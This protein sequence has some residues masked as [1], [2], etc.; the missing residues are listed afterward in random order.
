MIFP[1]PYARSMHRGVLLDNATIA[2]LKV[3]ESR[4]GYELTVVQ[5]VGGAQASA[6]TH[7]GRDGEGGRAVDLSDWDA[8]NKLR[9]LKNLGFAIWERKDR[10]G[11][12]AGHLHGLLI[13]ESRDNRRG[14][15]ES[16]FQQIGQYDDRLDG[17]VSGAHDPS[18]RPVPPAA[19][20]LAEYRATFEKP[21]P[22]PVKNNV[23]RARDRLV[24][25]R[26]SIG[27]AIAL[28]ADTPESR[29]VV[30]NQ[31]DELKAARR[32]VNESLDT[33]PEK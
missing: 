23:T 22:A 19:F 16:A 32:A 14:I 7:L 11:V 18:H 3:A 28:L 20:T 1:D 8:D 24:E 27:Q 2:A 30:H 15:A 9:V 31:M 21:E 5:G 17:L 25:A 12:W 10:P 4:L 33:L 13:F 29:T 26:Q 6:G